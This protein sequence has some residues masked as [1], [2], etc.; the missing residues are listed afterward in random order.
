MSAERFFIRSVQWFC[1]VA[2]NILMLGFAFSAVVFLGWLVFEEDLA[3][4]SL[5]VYEGVFFILLLVVLKRSWVLHS[6]SGNSF[7]T[8]LYSM[9]FNLAI[10]GVFAV[11]VKMLLEKQTSY[12]VNSVFADL[13][14]LASFLLVIYISANLSPMVSVDAKHA[15]NVNVD[16][17]QHKEPV[18][19][20]STMKMESEAKG[21]AGDAK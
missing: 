3:V 4:S 21:E 2:L 19:N 10:W 20:V 13:A 6:S 1:W 15:S 11:F 12:S 7:G 8:Y 9:F 17:N 16:N 18:E 5:S 14:F